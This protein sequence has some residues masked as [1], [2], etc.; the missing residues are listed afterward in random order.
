[1]LTNFGLTATLDPS[2]V[3]YPDTSSIMSGL[4][5]R[6]LTQYKYDPT[7]KN[8]VLVPDLATN[9]GTHNDNYTQW[10]FTI[11]PGV[12]WE[13]GETVTA[14]EVAFGM[15]RC[16]DAAT[17]PTG[18]CQY[19]SNAYFKGGA[20]YKGMYTTP[21]SRFKGIT[22]NGTPSPSRWPSPSRTCPTG[23]PFRPTDRSRGQGL[24]PEDLQEPPAG[25]RPLHDQ[26]VVAVQG[27]RADQEPLLG[28][29]DRPRAHAVP[30]RVRLQDPAAVGEDRSDPSRRLRFR[31]DHADLR[32]PAGSRLQPD[33]AGLAR[34]SRARRPAVHPLLGAGQPEDHRQEGA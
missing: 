22:V 34:P 12:K 2:E 30:R 15:T 17:F 8:M 6:S 21:S 31:P 5:T 20:D 18:A 24:E 16:M 14:Q 32:Q 29:G 26:V 10:T 27:A 25:H 11:R 7:T 23:A 33:A 4:V 1:M 9:L 3:Y 28:P 19:Y 13:N